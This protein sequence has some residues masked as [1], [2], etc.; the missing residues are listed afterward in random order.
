[1]IT[2]ALLFIFMI[3]LFVTFIEETDIGD[4]FMCW[5]CMKLFNQD[6]NELEDE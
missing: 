4:K 5:L 3:G 6:I 2:F 1:M